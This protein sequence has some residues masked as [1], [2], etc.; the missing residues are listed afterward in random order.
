MAITQPNR[1]PEV[2]AAL[3]R[4]EGRA[5]LVSEQAIREVTLNLARQGLCVEPTSALAATAAAELL[6]KG[7]IQP[8]ETMV[9]VP[10]DTGLKALARLTEF[11]EGVD[12]EAARL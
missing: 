8:E 10:T 4:S 9:I 2:L 7:L 1:L 6:S 3:C 5:D 12:A 11:L